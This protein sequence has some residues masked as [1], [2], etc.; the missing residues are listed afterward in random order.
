[1]IL[2]IKTTVRSILVY[3]IRYVFLRPRLRRAL[4]WG[5]KKVPTLHQRLLRIRNTGAVFIPPLKFPSTQFAL[6]PV[7]SYFDTESYAGKKV[8]VLAPLAANGTSGGAERFY[9]GLVKALRDQGC[10]ANCIHLTVDES[11]SGFESIQ[12]G[13]QAFAALDLSTFDLVIS[14]KA[15][16]YVVTHPNHILYLVHTI[17]VFYDMFDDVFP[18]A[19]KELHAQQEWIHKTDSQAFSRIT[20]RFS[21]GAEVTKRLKHWNSVDAEVLHPPIDVDGLHDDGIGDYLFMPG[22]LHPWKRVD[23]AIKAVKYSKLPLRLLISGTGEAE[24][25]LRELA[26]GDT[27]IEFLGWIDDE[28]LKTLYAGALAVP[29]VPLREDYGYVTL[30]AFA[31]GKPVVTCSDSGEPTQFV[32][33]GVTGFV[34]KP[35]PADI[36]SAFEKLWSDRSL[37]KKLGLAGRERGAAIH[38][39]QVAS[40]LLAAGFG[41]PTPKRR[42]LHIAILD[43]QPIMPAVGGGRLR[44]LGL[45]HALG[46]DIEARYI[47][48]YDWPGEQFRRHSLSPTLEEIDVPLSPSHHAAA[49]EAARKAGGKVVIDMLFGQQAHLSPEYLQETIDAVKWAD[50]VVFSHPWVAPLISDDLLSDKTVVYDSQNVEKILRAQILE[51]DEPYQRSILEEVIHAERLV[52]DRADLILACSEEDALGFIREYAW[53]RA[54]IAVVPNGVFGDAVRPPTAKQKRIARKTLGIREDQRVGFFIG[55]DYA[56]NIEAVDIIT[57]KIAPACPD[58][59]FVIAGGVCSRVTSGKAKNV[60]LIGYVDDTQ[61]LSWLQAADFAINPM[62]SGSGTNIKMFD[63]MAAGLPVISTEIGARGIV[64]SSTQGIRLADCQDIPAVISTVLKSP[65]VL[66]R[67]SEENRLLV[68]SQFSWEKISPDLG[69]RLRSAWIRK[70]GAKLLKTGGKAGQSRIAHLT[71]SGIKCGIAEY[72]KKIIEIYQRNGFHNLILG[73]DS[74][75]ENAVPP[76]SGA[77]FQIAWYYDNKHWLDSRLQPDIIER[78]LKWRADRVLVQYHPG[79]FA[80]EVLF[81][82]IQSCIKHGIPTAVITHNYTERCLNV[83]KALNQ[84]GVTIFSHRETEVNEA[85]TQGVQLEF[86]PFGVDIQELQVIRD[87]AQRNLIDRPPTIITNG[88]LRKHKGIKILIKAMPKVLQDFPGIKLKIQ[89]A[90]YP[91]EDSRN[92][93][94]ACKKEIAANSLVDSVILDTRFLDKTEILTEL[95]KADL[96]VLPY[97]SSNEGGSASASDA[98]AVGLPLIVSTAEIFDAI[99][100][101]TVTAQPEPGD[102][103]KAILDILHSGEKYRHLADASLGYARKNSWIN[104]AGSFL[105]VI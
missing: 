94:E 70:H 6:F 18:Q 7:R 12:E 32:E 58:V 64:N 31:S 63:F 83:F 1:M 80:P 8:A 34:C 65:E 23:L 35:E 46:V 21:I 40:R 25:S 86:T 2:K 69:L 88:F 39:P 102:L 73:C 71:T 54:A 77:D 60:K 52:G 9:S 79:F 99:R 43:M 53:Q 78:L 81:S 44:L 87:I 72:T 82:F 24:Q 36:C 90:L 74:A 15:P 20:K 4:S 103:A 17:R 56:P 100:D 66:H 47:G 95:S 38:W 16:T 67:A 45:Y 13:Y 51:I 98:F 68:E 29:F 33:D 104:V 14:T 84:L 49:A 92:E 97:E 62:C 22:R 101:V 27:R 55:S 26:D 30:E 76:D 59:K 10:E 61:R 57:Q 91:S 42:K 93:L 75:I 19:S 28:R 50:V 96:A 41:V 11:S 37:A 3:C 48:T 85:K 105:A 5:L 89:C